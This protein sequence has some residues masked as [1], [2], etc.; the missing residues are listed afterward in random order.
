VRLIAA[1]PPD[2]GIGRRTGIICQGGTVLLHT[3]RVTGLDR[4]LSRALGWWRVLQA[5]H[6]PGKIIPD[7]AVAVA[8]G[9][10]FLADIAM[11]RSQPELTGP[12][13]SDAVV[14]RLVT[15]LAEDTPQGAQK[16]SRG[17]GRGL[18]A[19]RGRHA[20][21]GRRAGHGRSGRGAGDRVLRGGARLVRRAAAGSAMRVLVL[22]GRK[23]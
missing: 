13:A 22:I 4:G 8:L 20:R 14:S 17:A 9:G 19:G 21:R 3:L 6:D 2:R 12:V 15:A 5:V 16:D 7:L 1:P 10:D 23:L 18:A 11:L